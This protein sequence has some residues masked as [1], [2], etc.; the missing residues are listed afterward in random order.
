MFGLG[1]WEIAFLALAVLIFVKPSELPKVFYKIGR[2]YG[3]IQEFNRSMRRTMRQ[4]ERQIAE[5]D[6][7]EEQS[8]QS[9]NVNGGQNGGEDPQTDGA[10]QDR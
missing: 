8:K 2:A 7:E 10:K 3:Q 4:F 9:K 6:A 1:F 5:S